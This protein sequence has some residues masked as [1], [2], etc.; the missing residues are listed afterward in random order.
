[1]IALI[2][3][4]IQRDCFSLSSASAARVA[5]AFRIPVRDT[6]TEGHVT[7]AHFLSRYFDQSDQAFESLFQSL[8]WR[9]FFQLHRQSRLV[10][11]SV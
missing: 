1:M 4:N 5:A 2:L 11:V 10:F 8:A 9:N 7:L 6:S 3:S